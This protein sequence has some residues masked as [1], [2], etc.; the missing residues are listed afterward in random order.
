MIFYASKDGVDSGRYARCSD[1]ML[2]AMLREC[3]RSSA[4]QLS[5]GGRRDAAAARAARSASD[6]AATARRYMFAAC[7]D[8]RDA[9][10]RRATMRQCRRYAGAAVRG[11]AVTRWRQRAALVAQNIVCDASRCESVPYARAR[12]AAH[13][14][15]ALPRGVSKR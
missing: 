1:A 5:Y 11:A 15:G 4:V 14:S 7:Y 6:V 8:T 3:C 13:T 9:S 12:C 10:R 2:A